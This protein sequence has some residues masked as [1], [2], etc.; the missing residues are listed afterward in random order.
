[1]DLLCIIR[2]MQVSKLINNLKHSE[3]ILRTVKIAVVVEYKSKIIENQ[4]NKIMDRIA[5]SHQLVN[6]TIKV[7]KLV[8]VFVNVLAIITMMTGSS[9]MR[10]EFQIGKKEGLKYCT[11]I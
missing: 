9:I 6:Q 10:K 8:I 11:G 7:S 1:M 2:I 4:L 5:N 3:R